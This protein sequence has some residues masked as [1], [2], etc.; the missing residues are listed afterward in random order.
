MSDKNTI[1]EIFLHLIKKH[2]ELLSMNL[3]NSGLDYSNL[4]RELRLKSTSY[5][6]KDLNCELAN[7]CDK[8]G[9]D[10]GEIKSYG[11][12]Y[13]WPSHSYTDY[14]K[15]LFGHCRLSVKKVFECGL[16]TNNPNLPS[17]MGASGKPGSSLR[18]W[19]DYF[20]NAMIYGG[21]ID[22]NILF[23]EERIVTLYLDQLEQAAIEKFWLQINEDNF[24]FMIDDGL[25]TFEAGSSLFI[26]S[27]EKLSSSGIYVIEDVN[28]Q[29]LMRY[30]E[31]FAPKK[32]LVDYVVMDSP[33]IPLDNNLV[34]VRKA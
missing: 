20:P 34:V 18:V 14:Y 3:L 33:N 26:N 6:S 9:S 10:K 29:D 5:Y 4:E 30:K 25:H 27:I 22:K 19:R 16:G 32:Y 7:L 21:D 15:R 17:S 12:P 31:F 23:S 2:P 28:K 8:Y 13:P 24:D 11:H 1:I